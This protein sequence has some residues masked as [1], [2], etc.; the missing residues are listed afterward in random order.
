MGCEEFKNAVTKN[1]QG[2]CIISSISPDIKVKVIQESLGF[3]FK[4]FFKDSIECFISTL[5]FLM[6]GFYLFHCNYIFQRKCKGI[7]LILS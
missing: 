1:R 3:L 2:L 5:S 7:C 4:N 6:C